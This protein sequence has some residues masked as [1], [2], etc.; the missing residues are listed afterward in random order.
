VRVYHLAHA[1]NYKLSHHINPSNSAF[2]TPNIMHEHDHLRAG[3]NWG[4]QPKHALWNTAEAGV[5]Q[6]VMLLLLLHCVPHGA[7]PASSRC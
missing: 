6:Q 5:I 4:T 3:A 1:F 2:A 7:A